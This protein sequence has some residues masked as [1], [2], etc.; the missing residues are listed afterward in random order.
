MTS[1][2]FSR[3][4][5]DDHDIVFKVLKSITITCSSSNFSI[6]IFSTS[7]IRPLSP[8]LPHRVSQSFLFETQHFSETPHGKY[9]T[10]HSLTA[11]SCTSSLLIYLFLGTFH[12][13]TGGIF[14]K[15]S[16]PFPS[17]HHFFKPV[18]F[19]P[20]PCSTPGVFSSPL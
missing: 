5:P 15:K 9:F 3:E 10:G 12:S 19:E 1:I 2:N 4:K 20:S 11:I 17:S 14:L 7:T 13:K 18:P 8:L 16:C 6:E